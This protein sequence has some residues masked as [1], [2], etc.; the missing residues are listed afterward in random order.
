MAKLNPKTIY[1]AR[2][3]I[4]A[5][6]LF[7]GFEARLAKIIRSILHKQFLAENEE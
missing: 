6:Y 3:V 7:Y 4:G 2:E 5:N 1:M